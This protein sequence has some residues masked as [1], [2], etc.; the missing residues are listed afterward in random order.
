M[1]IDGAKAWSTRS[2][3]APGA[4]SLESLGIYLRSESIERPCS[5]PYP[6]FFQAVGLLV[7]LT[8]VVL[9]LAIPLTLV[10]FLGSNN[11]ID[12]PVIG[13]TG[14]LVAFAIAIA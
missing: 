2:A 14:T 5:K 4:V 13:V 1:I 8:G 11:S 12:S 7:L 3:E 9:L 10:L 6:G